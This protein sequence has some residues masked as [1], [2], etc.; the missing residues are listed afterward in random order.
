VSEA[1]D[2]IQAQRTMLI[3][4]D[5]QSVRVTLEYLLELDGYRVLTAESGFA[6]V[7]IAEREPVDGALIDIHMPVMDGFATCVQ[8]QALAAKAGRLLKIWFMSGAA[9]A[10][11]KRRGLDLGGLAIFSKPF[12]PPN[13]SKLLEEGFLAASSPVLAVPKPEL[14]GDDLEAEP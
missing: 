7:A 5:Q 9:S 6:A 10:S 8:L 14:S 11:L 2:K 12:D 1:A 4:D 3:V 13:L